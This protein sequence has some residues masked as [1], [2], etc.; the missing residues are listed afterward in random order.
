MA[1]PQNT[2][3]VNSALVNYFPVALDQYPDIRLGYPAD[4]LS[5]P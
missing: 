1:T 2:P 5:P 3:P 4:P